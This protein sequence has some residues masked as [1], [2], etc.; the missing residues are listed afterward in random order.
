MQKYWFGALLASI[1]LEGLG[2]KYLPSI[3]PLVF[4]FGKDFVLLAGYLLFKPP[5]SVARTAKGLYRGFGIF[6]VAAVAWTVLEVLNPEHESLL[7]AAI[8]L[9]AYWLWW[10]APFVV[11]TV[12]RTPALKRSAILTLAILAIGISALAA[13]QF[14]SPT[15]SAVNLYS[16][17]DGEALYAADAGTV[18]ATGRARSASTFSFISGFADFNVLVP[19][20][21][22]SL[23]LGTPERKLRR[24]ALAA[25]LLSTSVIAT[26]GSRAPLILSVA[27][28][29][30]N[31]WCAGLLTTRAGRR[32]MIGALAG[33]VLAA[34]AFP[35]AILGVQ[36]RFDPAESKDRVILNT[37][38]LPPVALLA[39][40]YPL[41]GI[42]TG[43]Q[44]NARISLQVFPKWQTEIEMHRYLVELGAVG[45][46]LVWLAKFGLMVALFR[47]YKILKRAGRHAA[48]GAALSY[49][50][51]TFFGNITFDHIW[52]ALY[53]VGAGFILAETSAVLEAAAAA[54]KAV[55]DVPSPKVSVAVAARVS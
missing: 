34:V 33:G 39:L 47:A 5:A 31:C 7:L 43:M 45:F 28:L 4:Y 17:V 29:I 3:S 35:D 40:D 25:T 9:R 37:M 10:L 51:V 11:A 6:W 32:I 1:C 52:Q 22:L 53:F 12:L 42:G 24:W 44:Q 16:V 19:T 30:L 14:A 21:L 54:K 41:A 13:V 27:V 2:R 26:S 36:S 20:L 8:G 15:T 48:S 49:A 23:G 50:A 46:C 18:Y 38:V 55:V